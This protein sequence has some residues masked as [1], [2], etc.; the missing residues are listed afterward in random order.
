MLLRVADTYE[1]EV[2][3]EAQRLL[4]FL[5][6]ALTCVM[7]LLIGGIIASILLPM[8]SIPELAL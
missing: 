5:V 6:P 7:A 1:Q 2:Q 4:T 3:R 8:L